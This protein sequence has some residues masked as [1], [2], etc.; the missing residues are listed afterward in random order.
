MSRCVCVCVCVCACMHVVL[1]QLAVLASVKLTRKK[2]TFG[3]S[4][5]FFGRRV[6][7]HNAASRRQVMSPPPLPDGVL[8]SQRATISPK[9]DARRLVA[10]STGSARE[11]LPEQLKR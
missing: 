11:A 6:H 8:L 10:R 9:Q 4:S 3:S 2:K 1:A 5:L 7:S